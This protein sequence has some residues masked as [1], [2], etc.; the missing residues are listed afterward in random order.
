MFRKRQLHFTSLHHP[1]S[2]DYGP[3]RS[4]LF[5]SHENT[6]KLNFFS[7][8]N[9]NLCHCVSLVMWCRLKGSHLS[10]LGLT[11]NYMLNRSLTK[12]LRSST[13]QKLGLS[14]SFFL[15]FSTLKVICY[16]TSFFFNFCSG[17]LRICRTLNNSS[18][19]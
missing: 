2:C 8:K 10:E 14:G 5:V 7:S 3:N 1:R 19:I 4:A 9:T 13:S 6:S 12:K 17:V 15:N 11:I 18:P 16:N